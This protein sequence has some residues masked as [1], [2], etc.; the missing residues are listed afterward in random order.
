MPTYQNGLT[1]EQKTTVD[2]DEIKYYDQNSV[3]CCLPEPAPA[4]Q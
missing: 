4:P 2:P 1:G 3:W